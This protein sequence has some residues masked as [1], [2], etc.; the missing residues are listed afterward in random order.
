MDMMI[1]YLGQITRLQLESKGA[2][3]IAGL[4]DSNTSRIEREKRRK[5]EFLQ[6]GLLPD[7]ATQPDKPAISEDEDGEKHLDTWA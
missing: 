5:R 1:P 6:K 4:K 7:T 2:F 3:Y